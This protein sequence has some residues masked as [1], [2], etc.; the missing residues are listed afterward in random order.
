MAD[1]ERGPE[2]SS[3]DHD[4]HSDDHGDIDNIDNIDAAERPMLDALA[5]TFAAD[6]PPDG[7]NARSE[8]LLGWLD[9]D[10]ELDSLL[11]DAI[12]DPVGVR[13][14]SAVVDEL[15]L[16]DGVPV[17]EWR[18]EGTAVTG[19]VMVDSISVVELYGAAGVLRR[20]DVNELGRF[21]FDDVIS[22]PVR[23]RLS[24]RDGRR[25]HTPWF[26]V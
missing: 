8:L 20:A 6:D 11:T 16:R 13:D 7:M 22:G 5:S 12:A 10:D 25:E 19:L 3:D 23:L 14:D 17:V 24:H 9:V 18:V 2:V 4:Q 1:D 21:H 15:A 26:V